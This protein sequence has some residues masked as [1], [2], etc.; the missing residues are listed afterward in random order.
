LPPRGCRP[1]PRKQLY[2]LS[3]WERVGVRAGGA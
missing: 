2:P 1:K 3:L